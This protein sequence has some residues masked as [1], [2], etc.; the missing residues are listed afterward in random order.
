MMVAIS[1][2]I[3]EALEHLSQNVFKWKDDDEGTLALNNSK[4]T[5]INDIITMDR[6]EI[7]DLTTDGKQPVSRSTKKLTLHALLYFKEEER[8]RTDRMFNL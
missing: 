2:M 3:T 8:K 5:T 7:E 4:Y 1:M 6:D